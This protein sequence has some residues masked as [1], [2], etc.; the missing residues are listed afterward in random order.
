M[1]TKAERANINR[2]INENISQRLSRQRIYSEGGCEKGKVE[3]IISM[4]RL[5][6]KFYFQEKRDRTMDSN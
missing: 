5:R 3:K 6:E 2:E 1:L 4:E